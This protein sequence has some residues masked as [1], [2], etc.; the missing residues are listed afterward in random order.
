MLLAVRKL[1][2][3]VSNHEAGGGEKHNNIVTLR[4][5]VSVAVQCDGGNNILFI[6]ISITA[7]LSL[8]CRLKR[9][10]GIGTAK[11]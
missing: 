6:L 11:A 10:D 3:M 8:F 7:L 9:E 5:E 4:K 1:W 2:P